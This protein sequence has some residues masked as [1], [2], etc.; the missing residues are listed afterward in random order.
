MSDVPTNPIAHP[1]P[2]H[3][4]SLLRSALPALLLSVLAALWCRWT[5]GANLG[6]FLGTLLLITLCTP[7]LVLAASRRIAWAPAASV[8]IGAGLVWALFASA[9][10]LTKTEWFRC[11]LVL[12]AY[13]IALAGL[14]SLLHALGLPAAL[15]STMTV[16]LGLLWLAWP[17]WLSPWLTEPLARWL[18]PANP[19]FAINAVLKHLGTWDHAPIAYSTLTVLDQDIPYRLPSSIVPSVLIHTLIGACAVA[20]ASRTPNEGGRLR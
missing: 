17:V 16:L 2:S 4:S 5:V 19:V 6:L 3:A 14:A 1:D 13:V 20:V 10:D 12:A 7:A 18:V 15:A 8:A 11:W 9:A